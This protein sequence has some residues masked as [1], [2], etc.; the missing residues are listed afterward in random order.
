M[1]ILGPLG[2]SPR[3]RGNRRVHD[4]YTHNDAHP[5]F[6][7]KS[8]RRGLSPRARGN[9]API[10]RAATRVSVWTRSIPAGAGEP[11][12]SL[13][14]VGCL[15]KPLLGPV[16]WGRTRVYPRGRGGTGRSSIPIGQ[17]SGGTPAKQSR[18]SIP[19]GAGEPHPKTIVQRKRPIRGLSPRA[20]GNHAG[21]ALR[22]GVAGAGRPSARVYPRGRGGT[23]PA[24]IGLKRSA[25]ANRRGNSGVYPR[26]RGGTVAISDPA[27]GG[28]QASGSIPAGAGE[29]KL[30]LRRRHPAGSIPAGE[31]QTSPCPPGWDVGLS[32]RARGNRR[33]APRSP[34]ALHSAGLSP[35]ARG[36]RIAPD[37][38]QAFT[39]GPGVYPRGRGGTAVESS[40]R[41]R[42]PRGRPKS[43]P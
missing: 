40:V 16:S 42:Y 17:I 4:E 32:P 7:S 26:G 2:L 10:G 30:I 35:R 43:P 18:G 1:F 31:P 13:D 21:P 39:G 15:T 37:F 8:M 41:S 9:L 3:A 6:L 27:S 19:A 22:V 23:W 11:E 38:S 34:S 20:R 28:K 12:R 29:P 25:V 33:D 24:V 36:N 14:V 5:A